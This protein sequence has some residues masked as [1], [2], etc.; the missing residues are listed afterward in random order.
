MQNALVIPLKPSFRLAIIVV[1]AHGVGV[2]AVW[3]SGLSISMHV[4]LK[5]G[6]LTSLIWS[7]VR[8][9]WGL[10]RW[11]LVELRLFPAEKDEVWDRVEWTYADGRREAGSVLEGGLVLPAL[12]T[13][14]FQPDGTRAWMPLRAIPLLADSAAP[15]DLRQLRVRLRWGRAAPV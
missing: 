7:L 5:L 8:L 11:R 9:G 2:A 10:P 6:L 3:M 13:L 15:D 12:I 4:A 1:L 14:P